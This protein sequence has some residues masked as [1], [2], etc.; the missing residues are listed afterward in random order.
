MKK[1]LILGLFLLALDIVTKSLAFHLLPGIQP[2]VYPFGGIGI[3]SNF[4]GISFSLN[5]VFNTGA[6]WGL[7]QNYPGLLFGFRT[8]LVLGLGSYIYISHRK[9][10][11]KL[12]LWLIAAGAVGNALDYLIYGFVVDFFHFVFW[13]YSFPVFNVADSLICIGVFW[14]ILFDP[15]LKKK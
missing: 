6:A 1:G 3:F 10:L 14:L 9:W 7:F 12:S 13:G 5:T 11:Q 15:S 4:L 8:L 2:G